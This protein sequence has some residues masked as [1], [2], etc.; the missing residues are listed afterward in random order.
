MQRIADLSIIVVCGLFAAVLIQQTIESRLPVSTP[1]SQTG[2]AADAEAGSNDVALGWRPSDDAKA[3]TPEPGRR[4]VRGAMAGKDHSEKALPPLS[5][6]AAEPTWQAEL[7]EQHP[8]QPAMLPAE[9][10]DAFIA[11]FLEVARDVDANLA[12]KLDVLRKKDP[13]RFEQELRNMR[14]LVGLVQVRR[15][16]P[17]L[18]DWKIVELQ[19]E[20]KVA[21]LVDEY[22]TAYANDQQDEMQRLRDELRATVSVHLALAIQAREEYLC[23]IQDLV[24]QKLKELEQQRQRFDELVDERIQ[25]LLD[26]PPT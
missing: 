18:Y 23:K 14:R 21:R 17:K 8:Q 25:H 9:L 4:A 7:R 15:E 22:R 5:G 6:H 26:K 16:D 1:D 10:S 12:A 13:E 19:V 11:D 20:S 2:I 24:D 3:G